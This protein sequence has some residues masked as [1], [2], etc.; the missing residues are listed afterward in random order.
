M[1][2]LKN[3]FL[4]DFNFD[5]SAV[6]VNFKEIQI[7]ISWISFSTIFLRFAKLFSSTV[8]VSS[9]IMLARG[10]SL[11][12]K[13]VFF[14]SI[15]NKFPYKKKKNP[16]T[17]FL[18]FKFVF[19]FCVLLQIRNPWFLPHLTPS[20]LLR[21]NKNGA[22]VTA[23]AHGFVRCSTWI[24]SFTAFSMETGLGFHR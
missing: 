10:R 2:V 17:Y 6:K 16:R 15:F 22:K 14:K 8:V 13:T 19:R 20:S 9:R 7:L 23:E 5:N 12:L 4:Q 18:A 3:K 11:F 1:R 21:L 24:R